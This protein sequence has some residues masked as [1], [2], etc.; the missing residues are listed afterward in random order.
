[1]F[2]TSVVR[3]HV[4]QARSRV[5]LLTISFLAHTAVIIGVVA[6]SIASVEFPTHAPDEFRLAPPTF[7][8]R[9]PPP[10]GNPNGG[11]RPQPPA[12]PRAAAPPP[13]EQVA[14]QTIPETVE[15]VASAA[16]DGPG[17]GTPGTVAGPLGVPW[18]EPDSIGELDAPPLSGPATPVEEPVYTIGGDVKA[19]RLLRRVDPPY[20]TILIRTRMRATVVVR[21]II[22]RNGR[23]RD[24]EIISGSLPPFNEAVISAVQQW[25]FTPGSLRG[26][27]VETY[28]DLTVNFAVK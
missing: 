18:G 8:F 12:Q 13:T 7:V 26:Q 1:M 17:A 20:P 4:Q 19:P 22:D 9:I 14:P 24:P 28:L 21:C 2:E 3:E 15:P 6:A 16:V 11:A 5:S 10:L 25:R 27:A 23:V